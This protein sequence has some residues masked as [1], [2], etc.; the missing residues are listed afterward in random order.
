MK[1]SFSPKVAYKESEVYDENEIQLLFHALESEP[2]HWKM[3]ITLALTTGL[4]RGELV[5]LEWKYVDLEAG[6]IHVKQSI[7][8]FINGEP[9]I[10]EPKTKKSIRK[11]SL[12]DGVLSKLKE[13]YKLCTQEWDKLT[14]T[15]DKELFFVFFNQYV[16]AFYPENPYLWFR[17]FLKKHDLKYIRFHDLRHTS[18]TMLINKEIHAKIFSERL[19]HAN[20][21]TTMNIYGHVLSKADKEAANKFDQIIPLN[22]QKET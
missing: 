15:R 22:N 11:I 17:G 13:Y 2:Y 3:M 4:R 14:G 9:I 5:V 21:T 19:G 16:R 8:N 20:I 12:S 7:T 18:A 10:K 1:F 6:T